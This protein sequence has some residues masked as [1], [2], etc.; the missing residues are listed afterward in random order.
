LPAPPL[1]MQL[2]LNTV[3]RP[4]GHVTPADPLLP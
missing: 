4:G 1:S 3:I 2:N